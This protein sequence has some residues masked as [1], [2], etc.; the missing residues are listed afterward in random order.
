VVILLV[1]DN[2]QE[3]GLALHALA[4]Q[5]LPAGSFHGI[6]AVAPRS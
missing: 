2:A 6:S 5:V 3:A 4:G 1:E